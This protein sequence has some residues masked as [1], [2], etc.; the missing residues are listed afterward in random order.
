MNKEIK[1]RIRKQ[2]EEL[3]QIPLCN[4]TQHQ[5]SKLIK[6][7]KGSKNYID[8][9]LK[10]MLHDLDLIN[11]WSKTCPFKKHTKKII[12]NVRNNDANQKDGVEVKDGN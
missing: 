3:K 4:R 6:S 5:H 7:F 9:I 12:I 11:N 8:S 10:N 2:M 1:L